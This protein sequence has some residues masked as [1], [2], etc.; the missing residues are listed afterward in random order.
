MIP[1]HF[2]QSDFKRNIVFIQVVVELFGSEHPCNLL[3]LIVVIVPFEEWFFSE[4][5][6]GHHNSE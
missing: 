4:D 1:K 5:H 3:K 2:F 6:A